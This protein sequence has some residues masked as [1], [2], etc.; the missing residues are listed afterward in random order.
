[1]PGT[2]RADGIVNFN[3]IRLP[4]KF[5]LQGHLLDRARA[6][7]SGQGLTPWTGPFVSVLAVSGTLARGESLRTRFHALCE[8][9]EGA[10][11]ARVAE[12]FHLPCLELRAISNMVEDRDLARWRLAEAIERTAEAMVTLL[13]GL[14]G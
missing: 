2:W 9:M 13:P 5:S 4:L 7:L 6:L 14:V 1:M 10:A 8:N 11:V 12:E 3:T